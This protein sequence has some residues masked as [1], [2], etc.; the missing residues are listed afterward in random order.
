MLSVWLLNLSVAM[1]NS[2]YLMSTTQL[3][4]GKEMMDLAILLAIKDEDK[5]RSC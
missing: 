4:A 2:L 3:G 1:G 5:V